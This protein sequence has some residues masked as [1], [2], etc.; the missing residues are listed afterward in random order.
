MWYVPLVLPS[1][2]SLLPS[3]LDVT[4]PSSSLT[5]VDADD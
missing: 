3:P 4:S 5:V 1:S 2:S